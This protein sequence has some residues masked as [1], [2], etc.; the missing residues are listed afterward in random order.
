[1]GFPSTLLLIA[2]LSIGFTV[3]SAQGAF[4]NV[5]LAGVV[6]CNNASV[7]AVKTY[8]V[9]PQARVDVVCGILFF[10]RVTKSTTTNFAGIYSF[11][12]SP[13]DILFN[14]PELCNLNVTIPPNSCNFDPPGGALRFPI[15]AIRSAVGVVIDY[16]PGAASYVPA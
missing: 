2:L 12:F 14:N 11:S 16:V 15:I 3:S 1:M 8:R 13:V 10:Q 9:I 7:A 4:N 5:T 6:T